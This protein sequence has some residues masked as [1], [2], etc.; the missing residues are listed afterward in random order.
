MKLT[1]TTRSTSWSAETRWS[2]REGLVGQRGEPVRGFEGPLPGAGP[3]RRGVAAV[4]LPDAFEGCLHRVAFVADVEHHREPAAGAEHPGQLGERTWSVEPV[5]GLGHDDAVHARI[6]QR[7]RFGGAVGIDLRTSGNDRDSTSRMP[8]TGSIAM[9]S[10]PVGT[11]SRVSFPV[12]AARSTIVAPGPIR[13]VSIT[14]A[15][16]S[17]G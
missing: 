9:S 4:G 15:M 11:S 14:N 10:A 7:E 12:P 17:A 8:A 6:V 1:D 13:S 3:V 16:A 5:E 2:L